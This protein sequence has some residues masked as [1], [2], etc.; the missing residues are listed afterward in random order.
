MTLVDDRSGLEVLERHE[1]LALLAGEEVGRLGLVWGGHPLILPVNYVLDGDTVVFR[2]APGTKL[3]ASRRTAVAFEVDRF[4]GATREGWSVV[5]QGVADEVTDFAD[6]A[7]LE[8]LGR[9][10]LDP[11][12]EGDKPHVVRI[13]PRVVSGRRLRAHH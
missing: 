3:D 8:R 2:T 4:D 5:V 7:L 6:P 12:S 10:R 1:C 11:W 9:L 13:V